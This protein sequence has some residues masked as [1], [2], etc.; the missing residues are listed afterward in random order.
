MAAIGQ[1]PSDHAAPSYGDLAFEP[2]E[3]F[4]FE[5]AGNDEFPDMERNIASLNAYNASHGGSHDFDMLD[6]DK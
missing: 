3:E 2:S 6:G 1:M 5:D 4:M